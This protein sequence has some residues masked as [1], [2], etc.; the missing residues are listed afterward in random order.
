METVDLLTTS[1]M[2]PSVKEAPVIVSG[3]YTIT[4][5]PEVP[6][7]KAEYHYGFFFK[8][9]LSVQSHAGEWVST[10]VPTY[11][12]A[13]RDI[14]H[15]KASLVKAAEKKASRKYKVTFDPARAAVG[16]DAWKAF[17]RFGPF[18][19]CISTRYSRDSFVDDYVE[20]REAA[21]AKVENHKSWTQKDREAT[22]AAK[23]REA[24]RKRL[25]KKVP[26]KRIQTEYL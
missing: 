9:N 4:Y 3:P 26:S 18:W 13:V 17:V 10:H 23:E 22:I 25:L 16:H 14:E 7:W 20:S 1:A 8:K 15:H 6:G 12:D 21:L 2:V 24:E 11:E 19:S 5:N